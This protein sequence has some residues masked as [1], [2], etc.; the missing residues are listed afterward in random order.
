[1]NN[2]LRNKSK[3]NELIM[4]TKIEVKIRLIFNFRDSQAI[5]KNK[6]NGEN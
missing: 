2:N 6:A 4:K 5:A 3:L 1:M